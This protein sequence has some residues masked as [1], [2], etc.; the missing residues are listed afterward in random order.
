MVLIDIALGLTDNV[1]AK[2][3]YLSRR[4][5]QSR[6]KSLYQKLNIR[7]I[8]DHDTDSEVMN[9]RSRAVAIALQRGLINSE[10][11]AREEQELSR[12]IKMESGRL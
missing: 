9:P 7:G 8:L 5:V 1:I 10:E 2:R 12:W 11:L 6:L 3:R 4:G